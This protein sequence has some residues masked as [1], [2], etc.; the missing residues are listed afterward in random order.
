MC[1]YTLTLHERVKFS[2]ALVK[3]TLIENN[4]ISLAGHNSCEIYVEVVFYAALRFEMALRG[5]Y[6][7]NGFHHFTGGLQHI[8]TSCVIIPR[9][10]IIPRP[11]IIPLPLVIWK[12]ILEMSSYINRIYV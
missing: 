5:I 11:L 7:E 2:S 6:D 12:Y 9:S 10:L 4:D 3:V 1:M 8:E